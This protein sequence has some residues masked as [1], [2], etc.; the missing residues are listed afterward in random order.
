MPG[1][2][3]KVTHLI[4]TTLAQVNFGNIVS[5]DWFTVCSMTRYTNN[6]D[7]QGRILTS[8]NDPLFLHGHH[9]QNAGVAHYHS[10]KTAENT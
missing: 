10:W 9:N 4:G 5:G 1:A 8:I 2:A 3:E 6:K 7:K